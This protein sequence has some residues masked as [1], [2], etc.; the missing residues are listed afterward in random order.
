MSATAEAPATETEVEAVRDVVRIYGCSD[1]LVQV[2]GGVPG[3]DEYNTDDLYLTL[4][5]DGRATVI[6]ASYEDRGVWAIEAAPLENEN[7]LPMHLVTI[8][9][10][11]DDGS[12]RY[13]ALATVHG[14]TS[15]EEGIG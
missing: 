9:Q 11:T 6:R 4:H 2:E 13:S 5:G 3:C 7:G 14:V 12:C 10:G 1:D 8:E 15:I